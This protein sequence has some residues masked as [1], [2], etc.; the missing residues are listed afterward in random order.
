MV[1]A[2]KRRALV[3]MVF[4]VGVVFAGS[5]Y[6]GYASAPG[7]TI[8]YTARTAEGSLLGARSS[9]NTT[10]YIGAYISTNAVSFYAMD[11]AGNYRSC[12]HPGAPT[13]TDRWMVAS[14]ANQSWFRFTWDAAS[15]YCSTVEV[16]NNSYMSN[17]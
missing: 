12:G 5:A 7:V 6:A 3:G 1:F 2:F 11:A 15:G 8:N 9:G 4:G 10:E 17:P 16:D 14:I 13:N